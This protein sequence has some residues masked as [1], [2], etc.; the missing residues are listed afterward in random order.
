MNDW[1][2]AAAVA[3]II[4][5]VVLVVV[6][7]T[8]R[9]RVAQAERE[10]LQTAYREADEAARQTALVELQSLAA[11]TDQQK[12]PDLN[13]EVSGVLL[14][15]SERCVALSHGVNHLQIRKRTHYEG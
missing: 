1:P 9:A 10:R 12:W 3:G 11:W 7:L 13:R 6:A 5:L 4:A 2:T 15:D 14:V 8:K